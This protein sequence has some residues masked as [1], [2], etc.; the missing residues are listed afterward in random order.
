MKEWNDVNTDNSHDASGRINSDERGVG[1]AAL[2][3]GELAAYECRRRRISERSE[4]PRDRVAIALLGGPD[5]D[6]HSW[7][8]AEVER[9]V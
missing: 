3:P 8:R 9:A 6:G 1:G 2:Q 4:T 5:C 7:N